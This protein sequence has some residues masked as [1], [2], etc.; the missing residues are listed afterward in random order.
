VKFGNDVTAESTCRSKG[1][2]LLGLGACRVWGSRGSR[3]R[4]P[5]KSILGY[6][7]IYLVTI[8]ASGQTGRSGTDNSKCFVNSQRSYDDTD[9]HGGSLRQL[10]FVLVPMLLTIDCSWPTGWSK[11]IS[12][13][14]QG[15]RCCMYQS[16]LSK[17]LD[18]RNNDHE[19]HFSASKRMIMPSF[20]G[21]LSRTPHLSTTTLSS[22]TLSPH[23]R[24]DG[25]SVS[26]THSRPESC[27]AASTLRT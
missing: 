6:V 14:K 27:L 24:T 13:S 10:L 2:R 20:N 3:W 26:Y 11:A 17:R 15:E 7:S 4:K 23:I 18:R 25:S 22:R 9:A 8:G 5:L 19:F 21:S 1:V 16:L 12:L